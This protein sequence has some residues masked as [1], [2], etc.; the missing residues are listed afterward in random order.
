MG[1]R[2]PWLRWAAW[3]LSD[4][5][6]VPI[7][8]R[9]RG[10]LGLPLTPLSWGRRVMAL[11]AAFGRRSAFKRERAVAA[12]TS[13]SAT[14]PRILFDAPTLSPSASPRRCARLFLLRRR[15]ARATSRPRRAACAVPPDSR[16]AAS[17]L[18]RGRAPAKRRRKRTPS[19]ERRKVRRALERTAE[20]AQAINEI[21][22]DR[23]DA[24]REAGQ[25]GLTRLQTEKLD[26]RYD[27]LRGDRRKVYAAARVSEGKPYR[28]RTS[29]LPT[30]G[31]A[32]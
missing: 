29:R 22:G 20:T 7:R 31:N 32:A 21:A 8:G 5:D 13:P 12:P 30:G 17:G 4:A 2:R 27:D 23:Q 14:S 25:R 18:P 11:N 1:G 9:P 19:D 3:M 15:L 6:S 16:A 26:G 28:G 24:W 10:A